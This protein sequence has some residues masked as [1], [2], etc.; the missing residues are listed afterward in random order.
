MCW[1]RLQ[2]FVVAILCFGVDRAIAQGTAGELPDPITA[3]RLAQY[4]DFFNLSPQQRHALEGKHATYRLEFQKLRE[5]EIEQWIEDRGT[6]LTRAH[7]AAQRRLIERIAA[8]DVQFLDGVA[9]ILTDAQAAHLP[10]VKASRQRERAIQLTTVWSWRDAPPFDLSGAI[11]DL[12]LTDDQVSAIDAAMQAYESA[13]TP[14]FDGVVNDYFETVSKVFDAFER[15]G[16]TDERR[17]DPGSNEAA[18]AIAR[19]IWNERSVRQHAMMKDVVELNRRTLMSLK[20]LLPPDTWAVLQRAFLARTYSNLH[21]LGMMTALTGITSPYTMALAREDITDEQRATLE[22]QAAGFDKA[23]AATIDMLIERIDE[24]RDT[25]VGDYDREAEFAART[26]IDR[27]ASEAWSAIMQRRSKAVEQIAAL[28]GPEPAVDLE[29][30]D[31]ET[32]DF[33]KVGSHRLMFGRQELSAWL[34]P[35][36]STRDVADYARWLGLDRVQ[37]DQLRASYERYLQSFAEFKDRHQPILRGVSR[38]LHAGDSV[39][40]YTRANLQRMREATV[41][42]SIAQQAIED[43]FFAD[44]PLTLSR[45]TD[46]PGVQRVRL[47][48]QRQWLNSGVYSSET[49]QAGGRRDGMF[50]LERMLCLMRGLDLNDTAV[51][52]I[53]V[54]YGQAVTPLFKARQDA[55]IAYSRVEDDLRVEWQ[56]LRAQTGQQYPDMTARN[57]ERGM[58]E[59]LQAAKKAADPIAELNRETVHR[60]ETAMPAEAGA[61][62]RR[63]FQ[64]LSWPGIYMDRYSSEPLLT[65]ALN[66]PELTR[67]QRTKIEEISVEYRPIYDAMCQKMTTMV[68]APDSAIYDQANATTE[69]LLAYRQRALKRDRIVFERYELNMN[70]RQRLCGVLTEDQAKAI[71]LNAT[72]PEPPGISDQF[73]T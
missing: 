5:G 8:I 22:E 1:I 70:V 47:A 24:Y 20:P 6:T 4:A 62:V 11:A 44:V 35:A 13:L 56:E 63:V 16:W 57:N 19:P 25:F 46:D 72:M 65:A 29:P 21:F 30:A 68:E 3:A 41:A 52:H 33:S 7:I 48:R 40:G 9:T 66:L 2:L 43:A 60:L 12:N 38:D 17:A 26:A 49:Q 34:P 32:A 69:Q 50:D 18:H 73:G 10:R 51:D 37:I 28:I 54:E 42:A 36:I 71:G 39:E 55:M 58:N 15:A 64:R 61:R 31:P 14:K 27:S 59:L 23:L 67:Q 53:L 45:D